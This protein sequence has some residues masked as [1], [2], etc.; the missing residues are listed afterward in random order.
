MY[1][2]KAVIK[3]YYIYI[4]AKAFAIKKMWKYFA[5]SLS[6]CLLFVPY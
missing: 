5:T 3:A 4:S 6:Y 2:G 1:P